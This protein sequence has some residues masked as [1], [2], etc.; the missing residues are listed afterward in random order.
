M[1]FNSHSDLEGKHA[2]LSPSN[3]HWINYS[4]V[5]LA[6]RYVAARAAQKGVELHAF[7][8]EAIRLR[9]K[10]PEDG[11]TLNV[12]VNDAIGYKMDT[13]QPL[14]YSENCYGHADAICFYNGILRIHDLKTGAVEAS[15][16]QL[17]VYAALF[18][19][20]YII[21]PFEIEI[22][23]RIYQSDDVRVFKPYPET[24]S[25]I[26]EKI[27]AFDIMIEELKVRGAW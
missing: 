18:C 11:N 14:Y 5:K 16:H 17:E 7:A 6:D 24:I 23:L 2:F 25:M 12:Y 20:E 27:V 22:E 15:H 26:M 1:N 3:Y 21:T 10:L 19:L 4:D 13:E 9:I 8:H